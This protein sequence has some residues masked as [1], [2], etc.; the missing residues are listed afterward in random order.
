[1]GRGAKLELKPS[2]DGAIQSSVQGG[3]A[4]SSVKTTVCVVAVGRHCASAETVLQLWGEED[5][6]W[7]GVRGESH[8]HR[9]WYEYTSDS[10]NATLN[11]MN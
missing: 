10:G 9:S 8:R 11:I 5:S 4:S 6:G 1:M 7:V 2:A 3:V